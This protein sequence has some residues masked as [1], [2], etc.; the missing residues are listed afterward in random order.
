MLAESIAVLGL[1]SPLT[2][3]RHYHLLAEGQRKAA[4]KRLAEQDPERFEDLFEEGVPV[5]LIDI[6][7]GD[8]TLEALQI[9]VEENTQRKNYTSGEIRGAAR[10]LEEARYQKLQ[11]RPGKG[12][13]SLN[14][15]LMNVFGLSRRRVTQILNQ[16][17]TALD[18]KSAHFSQKCKS[19]RS[20][21]RSS[22]PTWSNTS[23]G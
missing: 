14:R 11:G 15:E 8:E 23:R 20:K 22:E 3:D 21:Q 1:I 17:E 13:K 2:V 12:Q 6:D 18:E 5:S 10:K 16:K 19:T 7:A 9:E 4:L